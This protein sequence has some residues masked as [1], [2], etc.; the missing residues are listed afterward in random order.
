MQPCWWEGRKN[1]EEEEEDKED[2]GEKEEEEELS[3]NNRILEGL[4]QMSYGSGGMIDSIWLIADAVTGF[5]ARSAWSQQHILIVLCYLPNCIVPI[6]SWWHPTSEVLNWKLGL[7]EQIMNFWNLS[8]KSQNLKPWN[9]NSNPN[10]PILNNKNAPRTLT[11][12]WTSK[13]K[14]QGLDNTIKWHRL[15]TTSLWDLCPHLFE[16]RV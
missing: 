4:R 11:Q 1:E 15:W 13:P 6:Q 9:V 8:A 7:Q 10:P 12:L 3:K 16:F 5:H 14:L 2:K